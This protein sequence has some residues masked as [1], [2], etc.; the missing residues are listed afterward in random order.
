MVVLVCV[1]DPEIKVYARVKTCFSLCGKITIRIKQDTVHT[2]FAGL[3]FKPVGNS[4]IAVCR[5]RGD[6]FPN[7]INLLKQDDMDAGSR[8]A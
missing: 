4:S 8:L 2:L 6:F 5:P 7:A 3:A 1:L